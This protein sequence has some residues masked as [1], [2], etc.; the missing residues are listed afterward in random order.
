MKLS[1]S[2]LIGIILI[3]KSNI[4][5]ARTTQ[6][7]SQ[8]RPNYT[9]I[10]KMLLTNNASENLNSNNGDR[11][12][13]A[14]WNFLIG[15]I[16]ITKSNVTPARTTQLQSQVR[17]NYTAIKKMLWTNNESENLNSHI[18]DRLNEAQWNFLIGIIITTKSSVTHAKM[19]QLQSQVRP[20]YITIKKMLWT[21]NDT[22]NLNS[23]N[24][25]RLNEA[26]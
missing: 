25:G 11:L 9:A 26:Q 8:V 4:I 14:K 10:K 17:P 15:I 12:N 5:P 19:T 18:A 16:I 13:E 20:N 21:N 22:E 2:F 7:Q 23:N 6:L 24:A 3:T 1:R